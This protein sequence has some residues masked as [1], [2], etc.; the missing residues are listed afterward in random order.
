M[1]VI[2]E[3]HKKNNIFPFLFEKF[4]TGP[5]T[6]GITKQIKIVPFDKVLHTNRN[7]IKRVP[8]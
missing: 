5:L 7:I 4:F 8:T 6:W 2:K 3:L 1:K